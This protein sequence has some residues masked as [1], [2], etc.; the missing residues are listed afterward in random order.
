M[1]EQRPLHEAVMDLARNRDKVWAASRRSCGKTKKG[2]PGAPF[3]AIREDW[4]FDFGNASIGIGRI[5]AALLGDVVGHHFF[6]RRAEIIRI[7]ALG[8]S[9][10]AVAAATHVIVGDDGIGG[11]LVD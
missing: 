5:G 6:E 7:V 3:P 1:L 9:A 4:L 8:E 11:V 10:V 2:R